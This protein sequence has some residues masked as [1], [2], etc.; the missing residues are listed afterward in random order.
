MEANTTDQY[1]RVLGSQLEEFE[2]LTRMINQL[3]TLARAE[4]GEVA[5]AHEPVDL[6]SMAQSLS[7]QLEPV[8]A[9]K[10]VNL[11]W[12]CQ[13]GIKVSGDAGWIER[14]VLNLIDNAIKFTGA[15]GNVDVRVLQNGNHRTLEV[16][17]SGMGIPPESVPH[18]FERFYRADPSRSNRAD[19]AGLGLSLVKWAVDQH[20]GS[21]NVE[22]NPGKG[23]TFRVTFPA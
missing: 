17:D 6:S 10:N 13:P 23:S 12:H 15:G 11:S 3:L 16:Q 5:M 22:T 19:G 20:H 2:K 9:S 18:I 14:I 21:V 1:R 8:A 7:E 4:S